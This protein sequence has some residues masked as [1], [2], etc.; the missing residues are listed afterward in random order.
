MATNQE[1]ITKMEETIAK[2]KATIARHQTRLNKLEEQQAKY[3][4]EMNYQKWRE[5]TDE[6]RAS[7]Y[8][9][10]WL[11]L[12]HKLDHCR[13]SIHDNIKKLNEKIDALNVLRQKVEKEIERDNTIPPVLVDFMKELT[14]EWDSYDTFRKPFVEDL[15]EK[16][17]KAWDKEKEEHWREPYYRM[18]TKIQDFGITYQE[19]YYYHDN[20]KEYWHKKNMKD[21]KNLVLGLMNRVKAKCGNIQSFENLHIQ[22]ANIGVCLN[23][24]VKGDKGD[25]VV[26]SIVAGGYNIQRK[27]I[28]VLVK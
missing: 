21:A 12:W 20:D 11:D 15:Y 6:Q 27:H 7:D 16:F 25:A 26:E 22:I 3:P 1:R 14:N 18:T 5:L 24:Y 17:S 4:Y 2:I 28:R 19:Y 23:G 10:D 13:D 8:Y 9:G